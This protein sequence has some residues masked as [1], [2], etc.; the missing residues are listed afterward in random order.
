MDVIRTIDLIINFSKYFGVSPFEITGTAYN[1]NRIKVSK[2]FLLF[3]RIKCVVCFTLGLRNF[4]LIFEIENESKNFKDSSIVV[5]FIDAVIYF[6]AL[7]SPI[8]IT[9]MYRKCIRFNINKLNTLQLSRPL[10]S[11]LINL[12]ITNR[13]VIF[14]PVLYYVVVIVPK[15]LIDYP[16]FTRNILEIFFALES[17][18]YQIAEILTINHFVVY[19]NI[20]RVF[21]Q[22]INYILKFETLCTFDSENILKKI[23]S[24]KKEEEILRCVI[25]DINRIYSFV[26]FIIITWSFLSELHGFVLLIAEND[27]YFNFSHFLVWVVLYTFFIMVIVVI[28]VLTSNEVN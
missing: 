10:K 26:I 3:S 12:K 8:F 23:N 6:A 1:V 4:F 14:S 24:L 2:T 17:F 18:S 21:Y 9:L 25:D 20:V 19:I 28:C 15:I 11:D 27:N 16:L 22:R 7:T 13:I 5:V